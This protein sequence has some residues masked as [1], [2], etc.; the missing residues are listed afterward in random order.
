MFEGHKSSLLANFI[1]N[2]YIIVIFLALTVWG[3]AVNECPLSESIAHCWATALPLS[4]LRDR[5]PG[6]DN[7]A[8]VLTRSHKIV[9]VLP[10]MSI[11]M[12]L[13]YFQVTKPWAFDMTNIDQIIFPREHVTFGIRCLLP[14]VDSFICRGQCGEEAWENKYLKHLNAILLPV[15]VSHLGKLPN[16]RILC[17]NVGVRHCFNVS[18]LK[19]ERGNKRWM[20]RL[21]V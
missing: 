10:E 18:L 21:S 5:K 4:K 16:T 8:I 17:W 12:G 7:V 19:R 13:G 20:V 3:D 1:M 11:E 14:Y 6:A 15:A 2:D 9:R